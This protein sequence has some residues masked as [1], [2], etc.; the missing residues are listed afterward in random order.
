MG[1]D[2][3]VEERISTLWLDMI[4]PFLKQASRKSIHQWGNHFIDILLSL[5]HKQWIFRNSMHF[6]TDGL[7]SAQHDALET[8]VKELMSTPLSTLLSKYRYLL[9]E[10]FHLLGEGPAAIRQ[11]WVA[12]MESTLGVAIKHTAGRL[13][14]GS[15]PYLISL[16]HRPHRFAH[17]LG[18]PRIRQPILTNDESVH[19]PHTTPTTETEFTSSLQRF[20]Q[21]ICRS[22]MVAL[23]LP[24]QDIRRQ[25]RDSDSCIYTKDWRVK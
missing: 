23:T 15:H 22:R 16:L 11:V 20:L 9:L 12:S 19:P 17:R 1:W 4:A 6:K 3:F 10:D 24:C 2:S 5:T 18:R 7:T 13:V 8:R 14:P 25:R 21:M